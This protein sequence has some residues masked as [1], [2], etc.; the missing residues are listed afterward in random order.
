MPA[1]DRI[2]HSDIIG[3]VWKKILLRIRDGKLMQLMTLKPIQVYKDKMPYD[4]E[5]AH[6]DVDIDAHIENLIQK[7]IQ[8]A[9]DILSMDF[10]SMDKNI[11]SYGI[12]VDV[13]VKMDY[14]NM[15]IYLS[16]QFADQ[17]F[18][19]LDDHIGLTFHD[20]KLNMKNRQLE[21]I[22]PLRIDAQYKK[23]NYNGEAEIFARGNIVYDP[24]NTLIKVKDISYVATSDKWI[25][26]MANLLYYK[27][28]VNAL[29]EFLQFDIKD[30]LFEGLDLLKKEVENYNR[31]LTLLSGKVSALTLN[32]VNLSPEGGN[33]NFH[34]EGRVKLLSLT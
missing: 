22:I 26:R 5:G 28:I 27:E 9:F 19:I 16:K 31:E 21:V 15:G 1:F 8:R 13:D 18:W 20:F 17:Q 33:A 25:L 10:K 32:H 23:L 3:L 12:S 6:L 34:V 4:L 29:E 14:K 30:E 11:L 2:L 7:P 24:V